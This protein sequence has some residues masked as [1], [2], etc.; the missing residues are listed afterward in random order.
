LRRGMPVS[1]AGF[2]NEVGMRRQGV[3]FMQRRWP[4]DGRPITGFCGGGKGR[5][6]VP[7]PVRQRDAVVS[8]PNAARSVTQRR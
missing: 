3:A 5:E 7:P 2:A 6:P 1:G 8:S 4:I